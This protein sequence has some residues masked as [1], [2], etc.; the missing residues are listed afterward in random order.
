MG[1]V[2]LL[3]F[4]RLGN[5]PDDLEVVRR[6]GFQLLAL[7][8]DPEAVPIDEIEIGD[9][10][11]RGLL[12]GAEGPGLRPETLALADLRVRIP[13]RSGID[14]LNVGHAAAIAFDRLGKIYARSPSEGK[15]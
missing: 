9:D 15:R 2:F 8:P 3:P 13:I 1:A 12:L 10:L 11:R 4:L 14:S 6:A 7:T 5:W